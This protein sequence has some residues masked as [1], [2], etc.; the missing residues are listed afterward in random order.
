MILYSIAIVQMISAY[1]LNQYD[2]STA[3]V[4]L[5][6]ASDGPELPSA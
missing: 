6:I 3:K 4:T 5:Q 2:T 1:N